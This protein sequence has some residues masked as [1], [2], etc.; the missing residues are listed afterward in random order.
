MNKKSIVITLIILLIAILGF[1]GYNK[2]VNNQISEGGKNISI[3]VKSESDKYEKEYKVS[4]DKNFLGEILD[5]KELVKTQG[6]GA[7]RFVT[8]V[9]GIKADESKQQWWKI[10]INGE[11]AMVGIDEIPLNDGDKFI[12]ELKT[13]W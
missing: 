7:G 4:T 10:T 9:D 8:E 3:I 11:D 1:F 6:S 2:F 13:G 12:L 5:E